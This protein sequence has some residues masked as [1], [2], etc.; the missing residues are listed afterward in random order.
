[1]K[2]IPISADVRERTGKGG[3]RTARREGRLPGVLYGKG[4]SIH[5]S[6]DRKEFIRAMQDAHGENVIF[7]VTLPGKAPLKSIARDV[8]HHPVSR[9]AIH[10][11]FQHIDMSKTIHVSVTVQLAGE[12][13]GVRNF[14]GILEHVARELEV[15]CLPAN[16]PSHIEIDVSGMMVGDSIHVSDITPENF[17]ILAEGSKVVAQVAAPTVEKEPVAEEVEAEAV[18]AAEGEEAAAEGTDKAKAEE[19]KGDEEKS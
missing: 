18:E 5:L 3:A 15:S 17:E 11:D 14:G 2:T 10:V 13:E 7:D 6:V 19:S 4:E 8:Q 16:I 9:G 1:M 12:P